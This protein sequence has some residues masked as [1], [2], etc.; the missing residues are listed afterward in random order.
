MGE[1]EQHEMPFKVRRFKSAR[2]RRGVFLVPALFTTANLLCGYFAVVAAYM[3]TA[4]DFDRAA[5]AIGLAFLFDSLDGRLARLLGANT[6]FGVQFDSL[7]DGESAACRLPEPS[8]A[9]SWRI[10]DGCAAWDFWFAAPG[11][12][13][14]LTCREW[15]RAVRNISWDCRRLQRRESLRRWCMDSMGGRC[16]TGAGRRHGSYWRRG[17]AL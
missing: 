12:W 5:K 17:L 2:V 10:W 11:G 6:D 15:R 16:M 7:A 13:R 4:E 14:D 8:E 1:P 9:S 3:G